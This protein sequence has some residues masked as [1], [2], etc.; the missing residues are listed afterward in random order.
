MVGTAVGVGAD[1]GRTGGVGGVG[2]GDAVRAGSAG[3][4]A[5][6]AAVAGIRADGA[7]A[8][9]VV[10]RATG[11][12]VAWRLDGEVASA[13][14]VEL[15]SGA[16]DSLT[17]VAGVG[18]GSVRPTTAVGAGV[19]RAVVCRPAE[20]SMLEASGC[21][22]GTALDAEAAS[23][24]VSMAEDGPSDVASVHPMINASESK[25]TPTSILGSRELDLSDCRPW[26][27]IGDGPAGAG[28]TLVFGQYQVS[29]GPAC[30]KRMGAHRS[31]RR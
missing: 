16:E 29:F 3:V 15:D 24:G 17:G 14:G 10:S 1:D 5:A 27:P 8:E 7:V 12:G 11:A 25:P 23:G 31:Q 9:V 30:W 18:C 21:W 13:T 28:S 22:S 6:G 2:V 4:G 19:V 20:L 26:N